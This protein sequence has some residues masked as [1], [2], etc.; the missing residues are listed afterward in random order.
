MLIVYRISQSNNLFELW[1]F[2]TVIFVSLKGFISY[3]PVYL[4]TIGRCNLLSVCPSL[5]VWTTVT[6]YRLPVH[7]NWFTSLQLIDKIIQI[8]LLVFSDLPNYSTVY[9]LQCSPIVSLDAFPGTTCLHHRLDVVVKSKNESTLLNTNMLKQSYF[10]STTTNFV[11]TA[12]ATLWKLITTTNLSPY[13]EY[14]LWYA[15]WV[16]R[17]E[18]RVPYTKRRLSLR[19]GAWT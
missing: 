3:H 12:Y 17:P 11:T 6:D 16:L 9:N 14:L 5:C 19:P 10:R 13:P 15:T 1:I 18:P 8:F 7:G 4:P 2:E